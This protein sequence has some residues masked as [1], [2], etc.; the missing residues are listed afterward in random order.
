MNQEVVSRQATENKL[1]QSLFYHFCI[2][3]FKL[4][5]TSKTKSLVLL[6]FEKKIKSKKN[7]FQKTSN[8]HSM[9][10]NTK[11]RKIYWLSL[12]NHVAIL[13]FFIHLN[14]VVL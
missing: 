11:K 5:T 1:K 14:Q 3:N 7:Q 4:L 10:K 9:P 13:V 6:S 12:N 8:E 2:D